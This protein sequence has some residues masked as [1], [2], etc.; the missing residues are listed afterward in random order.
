MYDKWQL[1]TAMNELTLNVLVYVV[2]EVSIFIQ[3]T[4]FDILL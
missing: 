4:T 2:L 3:F 1:N